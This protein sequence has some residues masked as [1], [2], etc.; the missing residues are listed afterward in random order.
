[1]RV[2]PP[3]MDGMNPRR[4]RSSRLWVAPLVGIAVAA[5]LGTAALVAD[6]HIDWK[7]RPS[8]PLFSGTPDAAE[9][10]L[11]VIAMATTTLLALV[12]TILAVIIQLGSSQ[13]SPRVLRTLFQD[14]PSHFT[15]GVFVATITYALLV[16]LASGPEDQG[17]RTV[18]MTL[19]FGMAVVAIVTF[20]IYANHIVHSVRISSIIN[21]VAGETRRLIDGEFPSAFDPGSVAEPQ[22][23]GSCTAVES[24]RWGVIVDIDEEGLMKLA[25]RDDLVIVLTHGIGEQVH[26]DATLME[27]YGSPKGKLSELREHVILGGERQLDRDVGWGIRILADIATRAISTGINDATTA[28]QS[29]DRVHALMRVLAGRS[30][31]VGQ[32]EDGRGRV[33]LMVPTPDWEHF[34]SLATDEIRR[35]GLSSI[36]VVRR[37]REMLVDLQTVAPQE[38]RA[39]IARRLELLDSMAEEALGPEHD[40]ELTHR[41]DPPASNGGAA[42]TDRRAGGGGAAGGA[43]GSGQQ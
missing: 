11:S 37:L 35:D 16:L 27:V 15:I 26:E 19:A 24:P 9:T 28:T 25:V 5:V 43:L 39:A 40:R 10:L 20:A 8:F 23:S 31:D 6:A 36:Q 7:A 3:L 21:R 12:F 32:L 29:L 41:I 18:G 13:Y 4:F 34:V 30:F 42:V 14:F 38:R 2:L 33:R 1:M 22:P 17:P